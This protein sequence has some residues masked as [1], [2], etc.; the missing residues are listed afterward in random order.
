MSRLRDERGSVGAARSD[1]TPPHQAVKVRNERA[2]AR[3]P[4]MAGLYA[5]TGS[6]VCRSDLTGVNH[7][8]FVDALSAPEYW[9]AR[10]RALPERSRLQGAQ[11]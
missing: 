9:E 2:T 10:A 11:S 1:A 7:P 8:L 6:A 3:L 5:S 4:C